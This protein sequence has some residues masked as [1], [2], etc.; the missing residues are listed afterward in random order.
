MKTII[1]ASL[2][3]CVLCG[4]AANGF[5]FRDGG[6][7]Y[8]SNA[9]VSGVRIHSGERAWDNR[10]MRSRANMAQD[11]ELMMDDGRVFVIYNLK[12]TQPFRMGDRVMIDYQHNQLKRIRYT[13][14]IYA[15]DWYN[16]VD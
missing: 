6:D 13:G 5:G 14:S 3:A 11:L 4:C 2:L 15:E 1:C 9:T 16:Y 10:A 12:N 8:S 7:V